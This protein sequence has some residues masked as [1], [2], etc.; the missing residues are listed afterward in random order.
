V[1]RRARTLFF[2]RR[3]Q[4]AA[5]GFIDYYLR[6][7]DLSIR[8]LDEDSAFYDFGSGNTP[9]LDHA[10]ETLGLKMVEMP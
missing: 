5:D 4:T 8:I 1:L 10:P 6:H 7:C 2:A 9:L 3:R